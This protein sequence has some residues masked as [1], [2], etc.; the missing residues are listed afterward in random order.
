[1]H[2]QKKGANNSLP[3]L[4]VN[5]TNR[6]EILAHVASLY[7]DQ[8]KTQQEISELIGV[9]RSAVSRLLGEA[10]EKG[11]VE[12]N[13]RYPYRRN[14]D[15]ETA[16]VRSYGLKE[17]HVLVRGDKSVKEMVQGLGVL[18][19]LYLSTILTPRSIIGISW[20]TNLYQTVNATKR[21]SLPDAEVV[22]LVGGTGTEKGSAIG[23]LLAPML[24]DRLG[25]ACRFLNVPLVTQNAETRKALLDEPSIQEALNRANQADIA[26]VGIGALHL[27]IYNPYRLG[28]LTE[29]EVE[30]LK[31]S[32][33]VGDICCLHFNQEGEVLDT[34]ITR[35][36]MGIN[37]ENLARIPRV[38]GVAGDRRKARAIYGALRTHLV[39]VLV[40]DE[41]AARD[42]LAL[43]IP[44]PAEPAGKFGTDNIL[45][46]P[47]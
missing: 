26:L 30:L 18:A 35:R 8:N 20:G 39:N 25:C 33:V 28:Y 34:D 21:M 1:L 16:L 19:A 10:R 7:Y 17:A 13:V 23:P 24:A 2:I 12:I 9:T 6:D 44:N 32:G 3:R 27:D 37:Q 11:I 4:S 47:E 41:T 22:Q 40:T 38:I 43:Q 45:F 46:Q 29:N 31:S 14:H 5:N 42:V 36:M 15:L